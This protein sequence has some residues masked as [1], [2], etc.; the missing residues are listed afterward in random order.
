MGH[1]VGGLAHDVG[2][3]QTVS[4]SATVLQEL[5]LVAGIINYRTSSLACIDKIDTD[6]GNFSLSA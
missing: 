3:Q 4:R 1:I 6:P 2:T 5:Q